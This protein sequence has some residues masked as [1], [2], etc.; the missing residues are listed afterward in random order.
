MI[1]WKSL[2][3]YD[4]LSKFHQNQCK[5]RN[6]KGKKKFNKYFCSTNNYI[7]IVTWVSII[8][9]LSFESTV[10]VPAHFH[11]VIHDKMKTNLI[12]KYY[13]STLESLLNQFKS[14][15]PILVLITG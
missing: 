8:F 15:N 7:L 9:N 12:K 14:E 6:K 10:M 4:F 13:R 11:D 5:A 2:I 1:S 3:S